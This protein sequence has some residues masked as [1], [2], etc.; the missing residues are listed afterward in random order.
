MTTIVPVPKKAKV[1]ELVQA[2]QNSREEGKTKAI[3]ETENI[4][5][6]SS[7]P[8]K[9]LQL[10]HQEH[11]AWYGN[12]SASDCNDYRRIAITSVIMKSFER[13]VKD[14]ITSTLHVTLNPM[15]FAYRPNWSTDNAI[16]ITLHTALS[17]LDKRN[18][19]VKMLFIDYS[20]VINTIS[21]I[22]AYL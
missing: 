2:H 9:V 12:C 22:Q 14:H 21:P 11:P 8:Q 4:W 7:D 6:G 13:L 20:S 3:Q 16:V 5:H 1:I 15:Q 19:Y 10:H 17:H 18:A